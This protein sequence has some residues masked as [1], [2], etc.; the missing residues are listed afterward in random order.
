MIRRQE[1]IVKYYSQR[2]SRQSLQLITVEEFKGIGKSLRGDEM[3]S[4][5]SIGATTLIVGFLIGWSLASP[6]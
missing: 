2:Q 6:D 5:W 1:R 3:P 4:R